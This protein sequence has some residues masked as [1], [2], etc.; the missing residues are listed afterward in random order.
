MSISPLQAPR[1][2]ALTLLS[3]AAFA[4]PALADVTLPSL[5]SDN[6]VLQARTKVNIW[7]HAD[8]K[9]K[10]TVKIGQRSGSA[11]AGADGKWS[12]TLEPLKAGAPF[13]M[14]VTGHNTITIQNV[15][16]GEVWLGSGQ[17]NMEMPVSRAKDA[18]QETAA[19]D[20]P[21]IRMFTVD[22]KVS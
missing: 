6:M 18:A 2:L 1:R 10:V 4:A 8:P 9:E 16:V 17:S 20:F 5:F 21:Q 7:G 3:L 11:V 22:R 13:E 19:A 14:T 15:A 12:V